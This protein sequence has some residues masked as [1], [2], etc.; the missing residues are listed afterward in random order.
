MPHPP[1]TPKATPTPA[2]NAIP[3]VILPAPSPDVQKQLQTQRPK[4][5]QQKRP[6][7]QGTEKAVAKPT[8]PPVDYQ[9]L[10]LSLA[11]EYLN[12]AH[13]HGTKMA[14]ATRHEDVE[15]YYK[16]VATGL[17]C[18]EAVLKVRFLESCPIFS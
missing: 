12:A 7:L 11:D 1:S 17:G 16:L 5:P 14:L 9:V 2:V 3:Q 18:L 8:K 6:G 13:R 10:L 4:K 15:E